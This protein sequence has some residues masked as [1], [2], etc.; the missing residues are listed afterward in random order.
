M[1]TIIYF[2]TEHDQIMSHVRPDYLE[3]QKVGSNG[4]IHL[5]RVKSLF[6]SKK[7]LEKRLTWPDF[8]GTILT[9]GEAN[10]SVIDNSLVT[11]V[12]NEST[13]EWEDEPTDLGIFD[14]EEDEYK[15]IEFDDESLNAVVKWAI[16]KMNELR[17]E[18]SLT[19][20]NFQ[21][22]KEVIKTKFD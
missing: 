11:P 10:Q 8:P 20:L 19:D 1:K 22:E 17:S 13:G 2:E 21:T 4:T 16:D 5:F 12:Y 6:Y 15:D 7:E 9:R 14:T 3:P 18:H